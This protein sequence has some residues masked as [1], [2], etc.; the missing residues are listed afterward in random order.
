MC[1]RLS[2]ERVITLKYVVLTEDWVSSDGVSTVA[3]GMRMIGRDHY[4]R[5]F[6]VSEID[7]GL[8]SLGELHRFI[9]WNLSRR[10]VVR[11][12]NASA[13]FQYDQKS[14]INS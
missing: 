12:V 11:R 10:V 7:S 13:C 6:F 9:Q 5:V 4:E 1:I 8:Y 14:Q 2:Y 3:E